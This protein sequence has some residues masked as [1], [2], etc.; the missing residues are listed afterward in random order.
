MNL[1]CLK[2]QRSHQW[3]YATIE[4]LNFNDQLP[5]FISSTLIELHVDVHSSNDLLYLLD[6]RLNHLRIFHVTVHYFHDS[7]Q[8]MKKV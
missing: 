7:S 4:R 8:Y 3:Y 2:F 6:G 5:T 1:I